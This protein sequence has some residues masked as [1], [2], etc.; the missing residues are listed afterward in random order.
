M[1]VKA[2]PT[3]FGAGASSTG[4]RGGTVIHVT[5]LADSGTGSLREALLTT[6]VRT[7]VFDISGIIDLSTPIFI[8]NTYD[9]FTIAGQTATEGG[10]TVIGD[11]LIFDIALENFIVRYMRFRGGNT[12]NDSIEGHGAS[13]GIFDHCS[14]SFGN[15]EGISL[16]ADSGEGTATNLTIQRCLIAENKS[17]GTII[18]G[19]NDNYDGGGDISMINNLW[20]NVSHRFPNVSGNGNY[21]VI[22]NVVWN[23]NKRLIR[24]NGSFNLNQIGNYYDYGTPVHDKILNHYSYEAGNTP[25]IY[26]NGNKIVSEDG[27]RTTGGYTMTSSIAEVNND[28]F[29]SWKWFIDGTDSGI[30]GTTNRG[31]QLTTDFKSLTQFTLNGIEPTILTADEAFIDVIADVGCDKRLNSDGSVSDNTDILDDEWLNEIALNNRTSYLNPSTEYIVPSIISTTRP[32]DFYV[33][34]PHI[35]EVWFQA[36]V[37]SGEDHN[38]IAPSGYTWLEEYLNQVDGVDTLG[39]ETYEL[40]P[41][42]KVKNKINKILLSKI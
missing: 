8:T 38:D 25:S 17:T 26:T 7:I 28:N 34:N 13:N 6:G 18:G 15:D 10:I 39:N 29:L 24:G 35:P 12:H 20:Y 5:T 21:D 37:P 4:G 31:E 42:Q 36:N 9:N 41:L 19:L 40:T 32:I 14:I 11:R 16:V 1:S 3:A 22:N 2:F 33:S 27:E 30:Y 23:M